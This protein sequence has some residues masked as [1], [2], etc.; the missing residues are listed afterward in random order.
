MIIMCRV[1]R[2]QA[3][4]Y[5]CSFWTLHYQVRPLPHCRGRGYLRS[6]GFSSDLSYKPL[7]DLFAYL[8]DIKPDVLILCGPFADSSHR[9]L[10]PATLGTSGG[11]SNG[12][13]PDSLEL[14]RRIVRDH[15]M[16]GLK[17]IGGIKCVLIPSIMDLHCPC[18]YPQPA[19]EIEVLLPGADNLYEDSELLPIL[20][21]N[22]CSFKINE[23]VVSISTADI[24]L[25]L[26]GNEASRISCDRLSRLSRHIIEQVSSSFV[27]FQKYEQ[28]FALT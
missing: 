5:C 27:F 23:I 25:H 12:D 13:P 20:S 4:E 10:D 22:P 9:L 2:W 18:V 16:K 7:D 3:F 24:L 8:K 11:F 19:F 15:I 17:S 26:S 14:I 1:S 21:S 28:S 6:I